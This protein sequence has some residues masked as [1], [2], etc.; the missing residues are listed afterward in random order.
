M[1]NVAFRIG[2]GSHLCRSAD[3][4]RRLPISAAN[5]GILGRADSCDLQSG[6]GEHTIY[7]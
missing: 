1:N 3:I 5:P 6:P 4:S 7:V 2:M